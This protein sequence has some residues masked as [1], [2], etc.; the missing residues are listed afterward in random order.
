MRLK[1]W[2]RSS[3]KR[4]PWLQVCRTWPQGP[5]CL[6]ISSSSTLSATC[7][8][9]EHSCTSVLRNKT[10]E[11]KSDGFWRI[12]LTR[13]SK[14]GRI[15]ASR[16]AWKLCLLTMPT[17]SGES[18]AVFTD[19]SRD[20]DAG[21][22]W[23][24]F[25]PR[26]ISD[27]IKVDCKYIVDQRMSIE[28]WANRCELHRQQDISMKK[29]KAWTWWGEQFIMRTGYPVLGVKRRGSSAMTITGQ[30]LTWSFCASLFMWIQFI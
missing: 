8:I 6:S 15:S 12:V 20:T 22:S 17:A 29:K 23:P 14:H 10:C 24:C 5:L 2:S 18:T 30:C 13:H 11:D 7:W 26:L 21:Y 28:C 3:L 19:F 9:P 27:E 16:F 1:K 25:E 4:W